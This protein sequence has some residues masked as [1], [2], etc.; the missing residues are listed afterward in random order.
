MCFNHD[1]IN[2]KIILGSLIEERIL[3]KDTFTNIFSYQFILF[4]YKIP[5]LQNIINKTWKILQIESQLK[6]TFDEPPTLPFK[7]NKNIRDMIRG[8]KAFDNKQ[9]LNITKLNKRKCKPFFTGFINLCCKQL[10]TYSTFQSFLQKH[11]YNLR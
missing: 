11:L 1:G 7:R 5:D 3:C 10:K 2:I 8:N 6:E 9:V 4:F